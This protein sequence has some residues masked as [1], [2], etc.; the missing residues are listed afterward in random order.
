MKNIS[1][2]LPYNGQAI[3][4][5]V[6]IDESAKAGTITE[7]NAAGNI[8]TSKGVSD[9]KKSAAG[10]DL[11]CHVAFLTDAH[12]NIDN[13]HDP[14]TGTATATVAGV[15]GKTYNLQ[16]PQAEAN[17]AVAWIQTLNIPI[18]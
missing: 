16:V 6:S 9:I 5:D 3:T 1:F 12:I 8:M 11:Y 10:T 13:S 4:I 14:S 7:K 18:H 17:R 15:V 2:T